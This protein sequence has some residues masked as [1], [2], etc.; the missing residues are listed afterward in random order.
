MKK[1][2]GYVRISTEDQSN[3]SID[4]QQKLIAEYCTKKGIELLNMFTDEGQSA[5][6]FD[7]LD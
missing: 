7:R 4:G 5:K 3:F 1:A 6:N 2:I